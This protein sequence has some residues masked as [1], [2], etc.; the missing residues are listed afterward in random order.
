[1]F[2]SAVCKACALSTG[3]GQLG[4]GP[5]GPCVKWPSWALVQVSAYGFITSS[6]RKFS[7]HYFERVR[8]PLV[9]YVNHDL[10]LEA[11]LWESLHKA[12]ILWLYQR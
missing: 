5:P 1:M 8:K 11:K 4:Q 7:N 12:R 3:S 9:F 2:R 10:P 6:Y